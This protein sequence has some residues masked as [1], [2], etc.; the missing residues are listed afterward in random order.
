MH[1][2]NVIHRDI[3]LDN[4]LLDKDFKPKICDFG[5]SNL[6]EKG[7]K[8]QDT[9]GTPAYLAPE[10]IKA[11]GKVSYKSDVWSLGVLLYLLTFG[12]VPFKSNDMQ[13]LYNKIIIG[14][15]NFP[16]V[17]GVST[18]QLDLIARMIG[19]FINLL[20]YGREIKSNN[21]SD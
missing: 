16:A 7:K 10:V 11:E 17:M 13:K 9:G 19:K 6:V 15:Y 12:I 5:I 21:Q 20:L 8:I 2:N 14:K 3:K 4:I 18:E 1:Q